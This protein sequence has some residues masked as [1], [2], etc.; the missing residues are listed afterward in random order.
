MISD[1]IS[2]THTSNID[3]KIKNL[4][5]IRLS[6]IFEVKAVFSGGELF[7]QIEKFISKFNSNWLT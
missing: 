1:F 2:S 7:V 5:I 4:L 6:C 3:R